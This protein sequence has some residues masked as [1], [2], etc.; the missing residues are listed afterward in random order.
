[1]VASKPIA[2]ATSAAAVARLAMVSAVLP[3][4]ANAS[5]APTPTTTGSR[6]R[7]AVRATRDARA[8]VAPRPTASATWAGRRPARQAGSA[9]AA[10]TPTKGL[11]SEAGNQ[12]A[13]GGPPGG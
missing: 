9:V 7:R 4:W 8:D 13:P 10:A 6:S 2:V 5:F 3:R 12:P 11:R 1:M